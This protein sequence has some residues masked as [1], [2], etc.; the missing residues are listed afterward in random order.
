MKCIASGLYEGK[1]NAKQVNNLKD[2]VNEKNRAKFI[3]RGRERERDRGRQKD[4][5]IER[6]R[7]RRER[8][9][10][11]REREMEGEAMKVKE[12]GRTDS[13]SKL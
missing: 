5:E 7:E 10:S 8:G 2:Q 13:Q 12:V 3:A 1:K 4:G 11:E 6:D 9:V